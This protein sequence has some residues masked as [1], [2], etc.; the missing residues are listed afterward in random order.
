MQ[1]LILADDDR[2]APDRHGDCVADCGVAR[3]SLSTSRERICERSLVGVERADGVPLHAVASLENER[4]T[5]PFVAE[6][7]SEPLALECG[8]L[9]RVGDERDDLAMYRLVHAS[10]ASPMVVALGTLR[11]PRLEA[12]LW[13]VIVATSSLSIARS[14]V[15]SR[16]VVS[17]VS[18][19][20]RR[21][22]TANS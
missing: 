22:A 2:V 16:S 6:S 5:G 8:D 1:D 14:A 19:P 13:P 11:L 12:R 18:N 3:Q 4:S 21:A 20:R 9:T 17:A 10:W 15:S 7:G